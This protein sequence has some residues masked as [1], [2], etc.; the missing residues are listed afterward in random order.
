M[1][2]IIW[3]TVLCIVGCQHQKEQTPEPLPGPDEVAELDVTSTSTLVPIGQATTSGLQIVTFKNHA[4]QPIYV[5]AWHNGC[6]KNLNPGLCYEE[7]VQP[8]QQTT[9]TPSE[10]TRSYDDIV[11]AFTIV[12]EVVMLAT[13]VALAVVTAGAAS[14][15]VGL[16]TADVAATTGAEVAAGVSDAAAANVSTLTATGA[17]MAAGDAADV[18]DGAIGVTTN[19]SSNMLKIEVGTAFKIST[20]VDTVVATTDGGL[21]GGYQNG[22]GSAISAG[23]QAL[24]TD[25][26]GAGYGEFTQLSRLSRW[27]ASLGPSATSLLGR[28]IADLRTIGQDFAQLAAKATKAIGGPGLVFEKFTNYLIRQS[29][30]SSDYIGALL[31]TMVKENISVNHVYYFAFKKIISDGF[32]QLAETLSKRGQEGF[33]TLTY[34]TGRLVL[35]HVMAAA[36]PSD[37]QS[38]EIVPLTMDLLR[39]I[40]DQIVTHPDARQTLDENT[41]EFV[42]RHIPLERSVSA[43]TVALNLHKKFN[44]PTL[45]KHLQTIFDHRSEWSDL[46]STY[47]PPQLRDAAALLHERYDLALSQENHGLR[48]RVTVQDQTPP[49]AIRI[50]R[51]NR[52]FRNFGWQRVDR[53]IHEQSRQISETGRSRFASVVG[54]HVRYS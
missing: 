31:R 10:P 4:D 48:V 24:M 21:K 12:G 17:T 43:L 53:S 2:Q 22:L 3:L 42:R 19:T 6:D 14:P 34:Q 47:L 7:L 13:T 16:E 25:V 1:K 27:S 30:A 39:A 35:K 36:D 8:G 50:R 33:F 29:T 11:R 41:A 38:V 40:V 44:S 26:V 45:D 9:F 51:A 52:N 18:A 23:V 5:Y 32:P 15:L 49:D 28:S 46:Y 20:T 54:S 37:T